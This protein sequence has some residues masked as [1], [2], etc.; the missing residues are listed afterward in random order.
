MKI[1]LV[2]LVLL[3]LVVCP[4]PHFNKEEVFKRRKEMENQISECILKSES[5][6]ADFKKQIEE[7]KDGDLRKVLQLSNSKL[8]ANDRE[9]VR[10]CRREFFEKMREKIFPNGPH[11]PFGS[12]LN[13]TFLSRPKLNK[14]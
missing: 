9:I 12:K 4:P 14:P 2:F 3:V 7:N 8:D 6:S 1:F 13:R 5:V 10:Q 11:F